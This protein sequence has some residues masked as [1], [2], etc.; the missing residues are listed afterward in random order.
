MTASYTAIFCDDIREET[1]G[2][3]LL[4][5]VYSADL[6][7]G[8]IPARFPLSLM[9]KAHGLTGKHKFEVTITSPGNIQVKM[10]GDIDVPSEVRA[11]PLIFA[12]FPIDL[13]A[14]GDITADLTLDDGDPVRIATLAVTKAST[15]SGA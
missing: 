15:A 4:I 8:A 14:Y 3:L 2:K 11:F 9:V 13:Q 1:N 7:P 6:I 10:G 12:G 5:G